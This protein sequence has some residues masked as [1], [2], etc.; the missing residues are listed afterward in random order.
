MTAL[1]LNLHSEHDLNIDAHV[2]SIQQEM[3]TSDEPMIVDSRLGW[4]FFT[5]AFKVHL[6]TEPA[7]SARRVIA[8]PANEVESYASVDEAITQLRERSESE[9]LRFIT[10]YGVDKS[11]L[12]NYSF[13]C[14][15]TRIGPD[16]AAACVVDAYRAAEGSADTSLML[17]PCRLYPTERIQHLRGLWSPEGKALVE[18]VGVTGKNAL[19]PVRVG[20]DGT[21]FFIID[22]H[23]RVSIAIQAGLTLIHA[24]LAAEADEIVI[25]DT[26]AS[27]YFE[28]SVSPSLV[29]DWQDAH[30]TALSRRSEPVLVHK[31]A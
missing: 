9:R 13:V 27:R 8:R 12:R 28:M 22:G 26:T 19:E 6:I 23:R 5:N 2:D 4:H 3:A 7:T 25:G 30:R 16:E 29:Y 31:D 10:R 11:R 20:Y 24:D 21:R 1:Q 18:K 15:T 17:D 14:D